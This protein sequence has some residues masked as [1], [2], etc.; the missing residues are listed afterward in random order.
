MAKSNEA[1]AGFEREYHTG[2]IHPSQRPRPDSPEPKENVKNAPPE[3]P[4]ARR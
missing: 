1:P 3:T 2:G 4:K